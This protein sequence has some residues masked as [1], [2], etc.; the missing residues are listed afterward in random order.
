MTRA[1]LIAFLRRHCVAVVS[2]VSPSG[3]PESALVGFAVSDELELVFDT[4][5]TSRK[6]HNLR[7]NPRVAVVIGGWG[8]EQTAQLE[9]IADEL[10]DDRLREVYYAAYPDGRE[11]AVAWN[12]LVYVR[13]RVTWARYSDFDA[14]PPLIVEVV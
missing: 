10:A 4:V 13:V 5:T 3:A 11:R 12:D 7:A 14:R 6:V 1:E 8:G 9:G 2:T